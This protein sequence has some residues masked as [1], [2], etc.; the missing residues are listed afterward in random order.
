M[1]STE[2]YCCA[3]VGNETLVRVASTTELNGLVTGLALS[4]VGVIMGNPI[5]VVR[6]E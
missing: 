1:L 5:A 2:L 3:V 6:M 4:D